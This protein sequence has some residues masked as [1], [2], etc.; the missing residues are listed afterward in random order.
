[1]FL[2]TVS[3]D[4]SFIY[5]VFN[6]CL[7]ST[8]F[9]PGVGPLLKEEKFKYPYKFNSTEAP[10][11]AVPLLG[12]LNKGHLEKNYTHTRRPLGGRPARPAHPFSPPAGSLNGL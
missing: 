2:I 7:L 5:S 6:T 12:I 10:L 4:L 8:Y 3:Y 9:M 1:M 11:L